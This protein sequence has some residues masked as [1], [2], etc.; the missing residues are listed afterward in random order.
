MDV[1]LTGKNMVLGD[2]IEQYATRK[3]RKLARHRPDLDRVDVELTRQTTR[4]VQDHYVCQA[5]LIARG[6]LIVRGEERAAEPRVSIDTLIDHLEQ[7]LQRQ[8]ERVESLRRLTAQGHLPPSPPEAFV[9]PSTLE[10]ILADFGIDEALIAHLEER[11]VRTMDQ[12]RA[13]VD[14]DRL[15][16]WLGPGYERQTQALIEVIEKLRL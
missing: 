11:G 7:Q 16:P 15:G 6:R 5:N 9:H 4:D 10:I 14:D 8:H 1:R 12:L 3:F 2:D 13:L